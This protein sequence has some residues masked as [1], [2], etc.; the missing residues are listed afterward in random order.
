MTIL[1]TGGTGFIGSYLARELIS[2]V[3]DDLYLFDYYINRKRITDLI[4][5]PKIHIIQGDIACWTDLVPLFKENN[6]SSIFHFG[7]LMPPYTEEKLEKAFKINIQ[8]TFNI[9]ELARHFN[10][11]RVIYSSS[12]A[13]FGPGVDLPVTEK[14]IRDPWTMYG[15]GKAISEI[16]GS[17][18]NKRQNVQFVALRFPALIGP[19]RKGEGM[20]MWANNIIQYP[21]QSEKA[22][23]NVEPDV[24]VPILYIKDAT[25]LLVSV[26]NSERIPHSTYN[27]NGDWLKAEELE[28][29]VKAEIPDAIINYDPD[30]MLTIQLKSW[31]MMRGD[32][33]LIKNELG[34]QPTYNP[35]E[36]VRD[37]ICEVRE[38]SYFRI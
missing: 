17:Y 30:P 31:E 16:L 36:F 15:V 35:V 26:Q 7:S 33:S 25:Q 6:F 1:I 32:D 12:G 13:I 37:F 5:N 22:T 21:A 4:D 28:S 11:S 29:L 2:S 27:I 24:T 10:V 14:T 38:K 20:T 23:C 8:G 3:T 34:F 19:G 18:Y 9:L